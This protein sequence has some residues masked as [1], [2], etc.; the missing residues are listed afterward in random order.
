MSP[1]R[2]P[3][4]R[5]LHAVPGHR[6]AVASLIHHAFWQAVPG[7]S[8]AGMARRLRQARPAVGLPVCRVA[9]LAGQPVGVANLV[10]ND[11]DDRPDWT[12]WLAGVVVRDD[13]RGQGI[14]SRLVRAVL[15]DAH[16]LGVPRVYFGTSGPG[17]YH[18]L[19][20]VVHEPIR[21]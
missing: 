7:A 16:R 12:P 5:H 20:A 2:C 8:V 3:K 17:F 1:D 11:A 13:C 21:A 15:A 10:A 6:R 4:I 14:G 18:R 9:L 19:G